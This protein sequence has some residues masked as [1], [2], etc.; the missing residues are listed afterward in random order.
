MQLLCQ[1]M[2]LLSC[3]SF[4]ELVRGFPRNIRNSARAAPRPY[5]IRDIAGSSLTLSG[6]YV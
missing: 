5:G 4:N 6:S 3:I 1:N 2:H